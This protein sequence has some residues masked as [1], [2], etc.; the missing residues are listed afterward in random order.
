[1]VTGTIMW[2]KLNLILKSCKGKGEAAGG[3]IPKLGS[4]DPCLHLGPILA[5]PSGVPSN[6]CS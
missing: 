4:K 5:L 2:Y 6:F 1:M 3:D